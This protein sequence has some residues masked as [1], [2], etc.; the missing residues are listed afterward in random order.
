MG[1]FF[2]VL[3]TLMRNRLVQKLNVG[4]I[5]VIL[6][7]IIVTEVNGQLKGMIVDAVRDIVTFDQSAL[8]PPPTTGDSV[9]PFLEGLASLD[10]RMVMVLDLVALTHEIEYADAA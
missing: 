7:I 4:R 1:F 8:Q 3:L 5:P 9:L 6:F 2:M 10:D